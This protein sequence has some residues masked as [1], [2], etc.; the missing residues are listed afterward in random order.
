MALMNWEPGYLALQRSGELAARA[1]AAYRSLAQCRLCPRACGVDR[2]AGRRGVCLAAKEAVVA[3]WNVHHWEEPPISGTRGSG[4]IFFSGCT[5]KCRFCQNYPI[6]QLG[7][8]NPAGAARLA[9]MMLELQQRGCHNINFVTPTHY[10]PH[11]LQALDLAAAQGLHVPLVYNTSGYDTVETLRLLEGVIDI[12]LP[13]A[14]YA[15]DVVARRLS[16]FPRYVAHNRAALQEM[17]RQAGPGLHLDEE[18]IA[19]R[20]MII[21]HLV[22]PQGLAGSGEVLRLI[23]QALSPD[24]H[25]SLMDQ[26]FPAHK[27]VGDP[28]IGRKITP[29]E[30]EEALA[31]FDA[32][33]LQNGWQQEH[34]DCLLEADLPAR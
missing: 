31:A 33:G 29:L 30:Y 21:R 14:K 25:V 20:G 10:V 1:E 26:Y 3:S 5:G 15:D 18:G 17:F 4:T 23:A 6:S 22:L 7:Y 34:D 9:E 19:R 24:L 12:W 11:I 28:A 13:D 27:A 8:G 16:G 2:L 32:A